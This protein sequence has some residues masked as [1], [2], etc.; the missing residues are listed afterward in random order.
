[1]PP[2]QWNATMSSGNRCNHSGSRADCDCTHYQ[3]LSAACACPRP[4]SL[5][6]KSMAATDS[7]HHKLNSRSTITIDW[8]TVALSL[9]PTLLA[10][11]IKIFANRASDWPPPG[12]GGR[13]L[14]SLLDLVEIHPMPHSELRVCRDLENV[15]ASTWACVDGVGCPTRHHGFIGY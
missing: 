11:A 1:M 5:G 12:H 9:A 2:Q 10:T 8:V 15:N 6:T 13:H 14:H 3:L 7:F 4:K